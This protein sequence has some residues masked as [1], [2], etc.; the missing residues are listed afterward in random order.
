ME[1]VRHTYH[2]PPAE[3]ELCIQDFFKEDILD[4][5]DMYNC[6]TCK[7]LQIAQTRFKLKN[8]II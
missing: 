5:K 2:M 1:G 6:H 4:G 8:R 3:F 7:G